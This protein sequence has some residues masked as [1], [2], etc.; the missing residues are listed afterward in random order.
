MKSLSSSRPLLILLVGLPGAGK[1][2]FA[3]QFSETFCAP[4]VSVDSLRFELFDTPQFSAQEQ[5]LI[6]RLMER[7]LGELVKT[8]VSILIDGICSTRQERMQISQ[9]ARRANY[10]TFIVW[11][12]TDEQTAKKRST[13]RNSKRAG[14]ELNASLTPEQF[15]QRAKQVQN[16]LSENYVVISGKHSYA[17]QAKMVLRKLAMPRVEKANDAHKQE[18]KEV[19]SAP[20]PTPKIRRNLVIN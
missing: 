6:K 17:T 7:Q 4:L 8:K 18:T 16:P 15:A 14:D 20:R 5:D 10:D 19:R 11:V 2:F 1:S 9:L 13:T 3:R 12:Q